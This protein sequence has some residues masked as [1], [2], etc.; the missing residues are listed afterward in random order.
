MRVFSLLAVLLLFWGCGG[1][2]AEVRVT[3][4]YLIKTQALERLVDEPFYFTANEPGSTELFYQPL[5][6]FDM[7]FVGHETLENPYGGLDIARAI[8]GVYTH[9]L[10][11][12]GKDADGLAYGF[13][14]NTDEAVS[15]SFGA[16][17]LRLGGQ[18][19]L[20]CLG[21]DFNQSGCPIDDH[22]YG[23]ESYDYKVA[24]RASEPLY[25]MMKQHERAL[26]SAMKEDLKNKL[27][28]ALPFALSPATLLSKTIRLVDDGREGGADCTS[29]FTS[30]FEEVAGVCF[31]EDRI[32]A[33]TL[34]DYFLY[35]TLGRETMIPAEYNFFTSG[36]DLYMYE[37]LGSAG[38]H[39]EDTPPR[40]S[41][42]YDGRMLQGIPTPDRLFHSPDMY[43]IEAAI[44]H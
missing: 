13:E 7:I 32:D 33:Q 36:G 41:G 8:P 16:T 10:I 2:E 40:Q 15:Y 42:C 30:L 25:A 38:Y 5:Q 37:L 9:M 4:S 18:P 12:L 24:R 22:I 19:Y 1:E 26:L 3:Q 14:M 44:T 11:Y 35:D 21:R 28:F 29:Y 6:R 17:G 39:L 20:Y 31:D 23:L 43:R 34:S 27:P